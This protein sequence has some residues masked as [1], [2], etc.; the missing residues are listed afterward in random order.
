MASRTL[1]VIKPDAVS[2]NVIGEIVS[3]VEKE[4]FR[5]RDMRMLTLS[6]EQAADFYEIHKER[7]FY[8]DLLEFITSGPSVPMVLERDDAVPYLRKVV[9]STN[10][11]EADEGTIRAAYGTNVQENSVHASDSPENAAREIG[12]FFVN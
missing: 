2:R 11:G 5:V 9:G 1:M 4:G 10:P 8:P 12:F 3:H 6:K 7:P